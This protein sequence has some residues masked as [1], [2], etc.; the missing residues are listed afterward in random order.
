MEDLCLDIEC[1]MS[2]IDRQWLH[3]LIFDIVIKQIADSMTIRKIGDR[4]HSSFDYVSVDLYLEG[5]LKGKTFIAHIKRDVHVVDNLR[6]KMLIGTDIMCSERMI[7]NLQTRKLIID[8]CNMTTSIICT[9]TGFR[10]NRV[11]RFH[12]VV[13]ISAHIVMTVSFKQNVN[14]SVGRDYSF[15]SHVISINFGAENDIMAHIVDFKT[16]MIHVRNAIDKTIT[17]SKHTKFGKISDFDEKDC[18]HVDVADV[19]LIVGVS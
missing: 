17:V 10:I 5:K 9:F 7:V 16:S 19:H 12:H 4:E 18:Y 3:V 2:L 8:S 1:I 13:T 14:L 11:V 15:Q 6:A